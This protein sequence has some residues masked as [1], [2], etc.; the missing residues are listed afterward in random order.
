MQLTFAHQGLA[1][2]LRA[3]DPKELRKALRASGKP[4]MEPIRRDA[5]RFAPKG[6]MGKL[7]RGIRWQAR[8][9]RDAVEFALLL[10]AP[11]SHLVDRGHRIV[12]RGPGRKGLGDRSR[13]TIAQRQRRIRL[14]GALL[15]RR[16]AGGRG[17]VL[18]RQFTLKA[19]QA[20]GGVPGI[21]RTLQGILVRQLRGR[22]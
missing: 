21:V 16:A 6:K 18:G 2:A 20:N 15:G 3:M 11:H 19:L 4:I 10:G 9:R 13:D 8:V 7:K 17:F 22:E 12:P 1:A 14:R 5:R